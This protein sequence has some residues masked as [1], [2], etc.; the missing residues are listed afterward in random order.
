VAVKGLKK[1]RRF[2]INTLRGIKTLLVLFLKEGV[3][4]YLLVIIFLMVLSAALFLV[5]ERGEVLKTIPKGDIQSLWYQITTVLYWAVVTISTTGY[6]DIT[7]L[8][9]AGRVMVMITILVSVAAVSLF[10]ANLASALTT[11]KLMEK[12]GIMDLT[13]FSDHFIICGW[14]MAMAKLLD[15]ILS[16]NSDLKLKDIIIIANIEPDTIEI[17]KQQNPKFQDA[18]II[19]GE[20]YSDTLLKKAKVDTCAKVVIIADE[21]NPTASR[22]EVDS[23]TIMTAMTIR[24]LSKTVRICAELLDVKFER[25]MQN[26]YVDE[27]IYTNEYS[28]SL[29][30]SSFTHIGLTKVINDILDVNTSSYISTENIPD[31]YL[32]KP[33]FDLRNFYREKH[34]YLLIGLVENVGSYYELKDEA[35][36]DAQKTADIEKLIL[37]LKEAKKMENNLPNINPDDKYIV[38]Q[39]S[40]AVVVGCKRGK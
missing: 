18:S 39:H 31:K 36:R 12:R 8:T 10:T 2:F 25:Y 16:R 21:S 11:K 35:L 20:H 34:N 9:T 1:V 4:K 38:P 27:L 33:F 24:T 23:K 5:I 37:N 13:E 28:Q 15:D 6:G 17:F 32:G 22:T 29:V 3:F 19:R 26:A 40:V 14:K 30:A 7:P